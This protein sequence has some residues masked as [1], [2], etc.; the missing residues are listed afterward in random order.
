MPQR[1]LYVQAV[2]KALVEVLVCSI[3]EGGEDGHR[4]CRGRVTAD[5]MESSP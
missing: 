4:R 1:D 3:A 2:R 5:A